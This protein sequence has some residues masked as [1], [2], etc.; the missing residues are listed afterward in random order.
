MQ[1]AR[2][3]K[4]LVKKGMG[5]DVTGDEWRNPFLFGININKKDRKV[6]LW[7]MVLSNARYAIW[8]RR[9]MAY[10]DKKKVD[11]MAMFKTILRKNVYLM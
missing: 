10:Y 6:N 2:V 7:N 1:R 8:V 4:G 5:K 3:I 11:V 9:N